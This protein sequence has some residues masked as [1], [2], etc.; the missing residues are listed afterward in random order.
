MLFEPQTF[1]DGK[2]S[3]NRVDAYDGPIAVAD[4]AL[5]LMKKSPAL[6]IKDPYE[7]T[8]PQY[9]AVLEV[10][11]KQRAL[12]HRYWHDTTVHA[13][14]F[15]KSG[16]VASSSWG[17][18]VNALKGEKYPVK[19]TIP[20][21]GCTGWA[22]TTMLLS[23]ATH[24]VCAYLWLEHS[25]DPKLQSALAE[26]F[27]SLPAV[28]TACKTPAPGG[29]DFCQVNGYDRFE[30]IHFWKTPELACVTQASCVPYRT[31]MTDYTAL[32]AGK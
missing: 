24:P 6:G 2:P 20:D 18:Q 28:P 3:A 16:V 32:K 13:D 23:D 22:D 29:T 4:A 1:P 7:L 11:K 10:L 31:W 17:Y 5:Y 12:V 19:S 27:G 14:D 21:E 15:K 8:G 30:T 26:W 9:A 25:L